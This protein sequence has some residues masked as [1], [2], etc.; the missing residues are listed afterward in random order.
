MPESLTCSDVSERDLI[1][2]YVA[3]SASERDAD[4]LEAH[5]LDCDSCWAGL[6]GAI[7]IRAALLERAMPVTE[8]GSRRTR[9][10]SAWRS[11]KVLAAAASVLLPLAVV[12]QL[13]RESGH[14][15]SSGTGEQGAVESPDG[16]SRGPS[17]VMNPTMSRMADGSLQVSWEEHPDAAL[18]R[19][20]I[21]EAADDLPDKIAEP[22]V[23]QITTTSVV[24]AADTLERFRT[25][26]VEIEAESA[27][28]EV[29]ARARVIA[30]PH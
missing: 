1:G 11:A 18:Y 8:T 14:E 2:R 4:A 3:G 23:E 22:V 16:V 29:V 25:A 15:A 19:L 9:K 26:G 10:T 20:R 30:S 5:A 12:W 27:S 24:I 13:S 21:S 6:Q 28:G 7:A 17:D